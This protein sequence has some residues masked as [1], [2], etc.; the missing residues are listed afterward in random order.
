MS[1]IQV[2]SGG[3]DGKKGTKYVY[4]AWNQWDSHRQR[5]VQHRFYVGRLG[6]DGKVLIN[7]KFTGGGKVGVTEDDLRS[8]ATDRASFE[9]WLREV[10]AGPAMTGGVS[11]VDIVGDSWIAEQVANAVGLPTILSDIFGAADGGALLGLA[12]H[13]LVTGHA[14]YRA[15]DWLSEREVPDA[16]RSALVSESEVHGF[17]ARIGKEVGL[18]ELF[19]ERWA[20]KHKCTGAILHDITSVSSYS[21]SLDLAEWGHNRDNE[22]LP[23]VNFSLA[24]APDGLPLFYRVIPGSIPDVRTLSVSIKIARDY[25]VE[26]LCLSLDRGFYSQSNVRELLALK[27]G[28]LLGVPWSVKKACELFKKHSARLPSPRHGFLFRG[29]PLRHVSDKWTQ[30]DV[31]LTL[32][33]YFDPGRHSDISLRFEKN[34]LALASKANRET[35]RNKREATLWIRENAGLHASCLGVS[36]TASGS[37]QIVTKPNQITSATARSGYTLILTHGREKGAENAE[38]VLRDYRDRD[39]AEKLFDAFKTENG[40]YRLRTAHDESVQGRFFLGFITL[41][42]RAD[43]ERRMRAAALHKSM[44]TANVFDELGKIKALRT[45]QN[46][47]ILLEVSKKQR[48]LLSSLQLPTPA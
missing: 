14:L 40:Q 39:M 46:N 35:F 12:A 38:H 36:K 43:I 41:I 47:R 20:S 37:A 48:L 34:V 27:C 33:L 28:F 13:Q 19:L 26:D 2:Q 8:H 25:G 42:L 44:T 30:D 15:G 4:L 31:E 5:S 23:Q 9:A 32:H 17:V 16:W 1:Y 3:T 10:A 45:R 11:R 22:A 24:A 29:T 7:K 6:E 21:P 18:R